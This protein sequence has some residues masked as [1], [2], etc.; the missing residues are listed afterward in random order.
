MKNSI[1]SKKYRKKLAGWEIILF[2]SINSLQGVFIF[3]VLV[4]KPRMRNIIKVSAKTTFINSFIL[5]DDIIC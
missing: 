2:D 1:Y 4:C 5:L 3:L